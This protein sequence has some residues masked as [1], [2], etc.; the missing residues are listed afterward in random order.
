MATSRWWWKMG[1]SISGLFMAR[2][3]ASTREQRMAAV[4]K[5]VL[6]K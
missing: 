4:A 6:E 2:N 3:A 5:Y 1:R